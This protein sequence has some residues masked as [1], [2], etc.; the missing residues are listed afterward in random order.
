MVDKAS[1]LPVIFQ[2]AA[3]RVKG[4]R[5]N[6]VGPEERTNASRPRSR[7]FLTLSRSRTTRRSRDSEH[8]DWQPRSGAEIDDLDPPIPGFRGLRWRLD[9]GLFLAHADRF[10]SGRR[11]VVWAGRVGHDCLGPPLRQ[12]EILLARPDIVS[13]SLDPESEICEIV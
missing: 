11:H 13:V 4:R 3:G 8:P 9:E 12:G 5:A 2:F 1:C 10:Q 7:A 6:N